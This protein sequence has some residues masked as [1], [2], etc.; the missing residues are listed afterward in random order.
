[1]GHRL[2]SICWFIN[3][4]YL[5]ELIKTIYNYNSQNMRAAYIL[6]TALLL[7]SAT[8]SGQ[9]EGL[10]AINKSDLKAYMIFFASDAM[11]GRD[12]GTPENE[13]AALYLRTN[14]MRLGLKPI[15][16]TGDYIQKVPLE[17]AEIK[18]NGTYLK[19]KDVNGQEIFTTD[20]I[21]YLLAPSVTADVTTNPVFAGYGFADSTTGYDDYSGIDVKDK[22][23][24]MLTGSPQLSDPDQLNAVFNMEIERPKI[25]SAFRHGA[26]AILC[27]YDP[28][29]KYADAYASGL[30]DMGVGRVGTKIISLRLNESSAPV[31]IAFITRNA[32][33]N[34]L[35]KSGYTTRSIAEKIVSEKKPHS[36]ELS[37][38]TLTFRTFIEKKDIEVNNIIGIV[39]GSDPVLKNECVI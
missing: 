22:V 2:H 11:K 8:L 27:V 30:A 32:A 5:S 31:Q 14:I 33:D 28:R 3:N 6:A 20:S 35:G 21:I 38:I 26:K 7:T 36:L 29:S 25:M 15:P 17:S 12:T 23:V 16:E 24:L 39:E 18:D 4:H 13:I 10:A 37:D 9:K 19:I 1:M 34:I